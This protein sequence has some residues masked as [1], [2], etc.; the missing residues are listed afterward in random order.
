[1][2]VSL[3]E[4]LTSGKKKVKQPALNLFE[5]LIERNKPLNLLEIRTIINDLL[6]SLQQLHFK[7]IN[8]LDV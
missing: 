3:E 5:Y 7:D 2:E 1:M 8:H 6:L 4:D